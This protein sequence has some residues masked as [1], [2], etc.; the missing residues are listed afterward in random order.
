V[1]GE[2]FEDGAVHDTVTFPVPGVA[3]TPVGAL[4]TVAGVTEFDAT[5]AADAVFEPAP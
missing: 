1:I 3:L 5:D 4:G 2:P